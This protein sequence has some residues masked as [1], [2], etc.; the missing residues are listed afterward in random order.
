L[1]VDDTQKADLQ[2]LSV[3]GATSLPVLFFNDTK[4]LALGNIKIPGNRN[5]TIKINTPPTE[6]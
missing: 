4:P 5:Q 2:N 1:L 3:V 6:K